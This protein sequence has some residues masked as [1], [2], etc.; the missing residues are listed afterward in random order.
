M[1]L[2]GTTPNMQKLILLFALMMLGFVA[3][4][5]NTIERA[6]GYEAQQEWIKAVLEY[7]KAVTSE[8]RDVEYRSRLKQTEFKAADYYYQRGLAELNQNNLDAAIDDYQ[9]GLIAMP[10]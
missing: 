9:Q 6:D 8:P 7:R 1:K 3:G 10:N 2:A 4:C 5:S